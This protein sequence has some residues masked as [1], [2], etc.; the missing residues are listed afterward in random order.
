MYK[1]NVLKKTRDNEVVFKFDFDPSDILTSLSQFTEIQL[2][3]GNETY[4]TVSDPT[5]LF[6]L[7]SKLYLKIGDVTQLSVGYHP[8]TI[9]GFNASYD[10][11]YVLTSPEINTINRVEVL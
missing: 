4:S 6:V 7:G 8:V 1:Q 3:I 2:T 11:G 10:D 5:K 9:I